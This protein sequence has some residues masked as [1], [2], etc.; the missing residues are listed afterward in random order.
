MNV[1]FVED[2]VEWKTYTVETGPFYPITFCH[3]DSAKL[4]H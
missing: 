4:F 3:L 2:D 1:F